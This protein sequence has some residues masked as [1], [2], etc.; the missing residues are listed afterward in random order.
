MDEDKFI[1]ILKEYNPED[2]MKFLLKN[3]KK[4]KPISPIYFEDNN[5]SEETRNEWKNRSYKHEWF[6][7]WN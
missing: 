1:D 3:G 4:P 2:M 7:G 5:E 6:N